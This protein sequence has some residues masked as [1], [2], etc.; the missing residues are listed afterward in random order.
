MTL[1]TRLI[2]VMFDRVVEAAD[3]GNSLSFEVLHDEFTKCYK[4]L[5]FAEQ[6]EF[7]EVTCKKFSDS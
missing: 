6:G 3:N 2:L 5:D 1:D 4:K 7:H